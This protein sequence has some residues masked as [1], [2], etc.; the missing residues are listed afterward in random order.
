ML[1]RYRSTRNFLFKLHVEKKFCLL[2]R[3]SRRER[4]DFGIQKHGRS[5]C[6]ERGPGPKRNRNRS[7]D[8]N[9]D[10]AENCN[11]K[12]DPN[13][14]GIRCIGAR[15]DS[16]C[17]N[18]RREVKGPLLEQKFSRSL[19]A[20]K[21]SACLEKNLGTETQPEPVKS[22]GF[23]FANTRETLNREIAFSAQQ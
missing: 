20:P 17:W 16:R 2:S 14:A 4:A 23:T 22:N 1:L 3:F 7:R 19:R 12:P 5:A 8:R 11:P 9:L 10:F 6:L 15:G 21:P 13:S 18:P